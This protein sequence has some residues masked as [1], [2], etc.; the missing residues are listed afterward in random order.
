MFPRILS[1]QLQHFFRSHYLTKTHADN[2]YCR[3]VPRRIKGG[4]AIR[5]ENNIIPIG[6]CLTA[7]SISMLSILSEYI[8]KAIEI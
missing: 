4:T 6:N 3:F 8:E 7:C 5:N 2:L 1:E